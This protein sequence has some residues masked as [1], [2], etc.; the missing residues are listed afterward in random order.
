M[1]SEWSSR[2]LLA[3]LALLT[4]LSAARLLLVVVVV[5]TPSLWSIARRKNLLGARA[6]F[7]MK[8]T[9]YISAHKIC[10]FTLDKCSILCPKKIS[11]LENPPP[12]IWEFKGFLEFLVKDVE[13]TTSA[14]LC[15]LAKGD[16]VDLSQ[17][18]GKGFDTDQLY[19]PEKFQTLLFFATGSD[20]RHFFSSFHSRSFISWDSLRHGVSIIPILS[21]TDG[22][23]MGE[24][25][26]VQDV[27]DLLSAEGVPQEKI[28]LNF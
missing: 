28:I 2:P 1:A 19:P 21:Q 5:E 8:D 16:K 17:V 26:Y 23:W 7:S 18:V 11:K 10:F 15:D 27:T 14:V 20:I 4:S 13:G 24:S 3:P 12:K 22:S 25:G 6:T 9:Y